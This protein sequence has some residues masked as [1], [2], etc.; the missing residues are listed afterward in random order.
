MRTTMKQLSESLKLIPIPIMI[1]HPLELIM[2]HGPH[3]M[4]TE[5][6][7]FQ[8]LQRDGRYIEAIIFNI[9]YFSGIDSVKFWRVLFHE[10]AHATGQ[11]SRLSRASVNLAMRE[12]RSERQCCIEE[13][14]AERTSQKAMTHFGLFH[15]DTTASSK[16]YIS[17]YIE[18]MD[19][20]GM[21]LT[22]IESYQIERDSDRALAYMLQNW[23]QS[24]NGALQKVA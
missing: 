13:L 9:M 21:P 7:Y 6:T 5:A 20:M 23:F 18:K 1:K 10:L 19:A 22:E 2:M 17:T 3:A 15:D 24:Q 4:F 11:H 8:A 16:E 12:T 14:I